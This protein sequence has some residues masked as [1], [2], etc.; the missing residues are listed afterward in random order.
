MLAGLERMNSGIENSTFP[1]RSTVTG[2]Y[3][4]HVC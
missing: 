1:L 2:Q 4:L 3:R